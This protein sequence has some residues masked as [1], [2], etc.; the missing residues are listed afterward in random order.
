MFKNYI[1]V[2]LRNIIKNRLYAFINIV[3]LAIGLAVFVFGSVLV[4]YE[5]NHDSIFPKLDR[6]YTV[7]SII[8]PSAGFGIQRTDSTYAAFGQYIPGG[9][10]QVEASATVKRREFLASI[11][12]NDF[13]QDI[14]FT[15]PAFTAIFDL[16]YLYGDA[17]VLQDPTA[18]IL[19]RSA[20]ERLFGEAS[21]N[22]QT[23][24]LDHGYEMTV[25]AV[26]EDLPADTHFNSSL[27]GEPEFSSLANFT[28]LKQI[29]GYDN[30]EDWNNLSLGERTYILAPEGH[31]LETLNA[32]LHALYQQHY[33]E[34]IKELVVR[35]ELSPLTLA[36]TFFWDAVGMPVITSIYVLAFLVLV[37]AC[38]NY[39]NL[40][41]A[42]N[43]GR[44][45]EV[46]LRRTL[47]A[48]RRQLLIQFL[49]ESIIIAMI[50]MF[51]ALVGVELIVPLF[52]QS[53]GKVLSVDHLA[54]LPWLTFT[55]LSV[56]LVS[57]GYPAY[58]ITRT[59][60]IQALRDG[61]KKGAAKSAMRSI[62]IGVQFVIAIFMLAT[63]L[64]MY[65]QNQK[66]RDTIN[67][68]PTEQ[69][70]VLER[71][72][73]DGVSDKMET[74]K[75][76]LKRLPN[77]E[78]VS[79]MSQV[80]FEQNNSVFD[81]TRIS[82]D[83]PGSFRINRVWIDYDF[84]QTLEVP[85]LAG[86]DISRNV[87][88]DMLR[89]GEQSQNIIVNELA[90]KQLGF[91]S[92]QEA[93]GQSF[94]DIPDEGDETYQFTIVGVV[95]DQN[96]LGF[97]NEIKPFVFM[98][99]TGRRVAAVRFKPL[100]V[101]Q[102]VADIE[103]VWDRVIPDYP[104]QSRFLSETFEGVYV[105]YR[106]I[107]IAFAGFAFLALSLALIG[108]FGLAAFMAEQRTREIGIRRVMG[109]SVQ[110]VVRLLIWQFSKPVIWALFVA[111]PAAYLGMNLYLDFFSDRIA[112]PVGI[113]AI[114]GMIGVFAAWG[115]VA[116]H[117]ATVARSNPVNALRYE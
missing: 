1:T 34:D 28:A 46:G 109:A 27:T 47:G 91:S 21:P 70:L 23:L 88:S 81:A 18:I 90:T 111:L 105:I 5:Q 30:T 64:V 69:I 40:A 110:Q 75:A 29:N 38:V 56:A 82:G 67:L 45:R 14:R 62:M 52:N 35:L 11:G 112:L 93:I 19:T 17:S 6:I 59:T 44:A 85:L 92:P 42:Q 9:M 50:A 98:G 2:A 71:L 94:Y 108:L 8:S 20:A 12:G 97:H 79:V 13:Y 116:M 95:E 106:S 100:N 10:P 37:V 55:V 101:Q 103:A 57:G 117:A 7:N 54:A 51:I 49:T 24:T 104:M 32:S 63:V 25:R 78:N 68:Y 66:V 3:G 65:F 61:G 74:L 16:Q 53:S 107:N 102:T 73:V 113:I 39:A 4:D 58:L 31:D 114:A 43:M 86:R 72:G 96:F 99:A 115:I 26:V 84:L 83:E 48:G 80:P 77:V 87:A 60:P 22:G 89:D 76:E 15:D 33:P 36:N 41:T